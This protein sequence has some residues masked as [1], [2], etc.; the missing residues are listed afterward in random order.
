M[1]TGFPVVRG[2][3]GAG[4]YALALLVVE[5]DSEGDGGNVSLAHGQLPFLLPSGV[6]VRPPIIHISKPLTLLLN[7]RFRDCRG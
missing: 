5:V 2:F 1:K 3:K 4:R 7:S 6:T